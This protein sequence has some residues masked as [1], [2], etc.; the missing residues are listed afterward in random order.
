MILHATGS[1]DCIVLLWLAIE[2]TNLKRFLPSRKNGQSEAV[3]DEQVAPAKI[4]CVGVPPVTQPGEPEEQWAAL[5][6]LTNVTLHSFWEGQGWEV[7]V[8]LIYDLSDCER[9]GKLKQGEEISCWVVGWWEVTEREEELKGLGK[10][11]RAWREATTTWG[12][13]E[14]GMDLGSEQWKAVVEALSFH[15][16]GLSSLQGTGW[17]EK[18]KMYVLDHVFWSAFSLLKSYS[19][20]CILSVITSFSQENVLSLLRIRHYVNNAVAQIHLQSQKAFTIMVYMWQWIKYIFT[21]PFFSTAWFITVVL[22][23]HEVN[24][25]VVEAVNIV[26]GAVQIIVKLHVMQPWYCNASQMYDLS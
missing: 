7:A 15:L 8:S 24:A 25:S 26:T 3:G 1:M 16:P 2:P 22:C 20:P 11:R 4:P 13:L 10:D 12:R 21:L 14:D 9:S 6:R 17:D 5:A 18:G 19:I 23:L